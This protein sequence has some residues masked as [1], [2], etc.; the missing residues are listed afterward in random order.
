MLAGAFALAYHDGIGDSHLCHRVASF[1]CVISFVRPFT[2]SRCA[3]N[4]SR[5]APRIDRCDVPATVFLGAFRS[6]APG[7]LWLPTASTLHSPPVRHRPPL[8]VPSCA[9]PLLRL[10][11]FLRLW[12][13]FDIAALRIVAAADKRRSIT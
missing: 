3:V 9:L 7:S 5:P 10:W 4:S 11:L 2:A 6:D 12:L 13:L 8:R 1:S